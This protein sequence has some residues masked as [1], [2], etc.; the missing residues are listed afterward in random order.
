MRIAN[1]RYHVR[2]YVPTPPALYLWH[3]GAKTKKGG[4]LSFEGGHIIP[5]VVTAP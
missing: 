3:S 4:G 5:S 2:T 1:D